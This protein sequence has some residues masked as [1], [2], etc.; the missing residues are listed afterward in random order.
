MSQGKENHRP[1]LKPI[2]LQTRNVRNFQMLLD[3]LRDSGGEGCLGALR[4][5]RPRR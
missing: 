2:F 1:R 4:Q 5:R 3:G